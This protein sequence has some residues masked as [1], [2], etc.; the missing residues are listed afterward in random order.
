MIK[1]RRK[2]TTS[3][4]AYANVNFKNGIPMSQNIKQ[5]IIDKLELKMKMSNVMK[6]EF[7]KIHLKHYPMTAG[8]SLA[9]DDKHRF[10][11]IKAFDYNR[12]ILRKINNQEDSDYINASYIKDCEGQRRFIASQ[13]P[14]K[15]TLN[16]MWRMIWQ[17]NI[18]YIVMLTNLKE[19]DRVKCQRYWPESGTTTYHNIRVELETS[20]EYSFFI[21][22]QFTISCHNKVRTLTQI[23]YINWPDH[24][25]PDTAAEVLYLYFK[26]KTQQ[27][28]E[29]GPLLVH[30]SAGVGRTGTFIALDNLLEQ[31]KTEIIDVFQ[32]V[33]LL[34]K[35][36]V[37]MVQTE[38]QYR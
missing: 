21:E 27:T 16:D 15:C 24:G 19:G 22:R 33:N 12:V 4:I 38:N 6:K 7:D 3:N 10:K 8:D 28:E 13:A 1:N 18:S 37:Q 5:R 31:N 35:Q 29:S 36:R 20:N 23:Q 25:V 17:E 9:N 11:N 32:C 2:L 30:C 26:V 34:R 14:R